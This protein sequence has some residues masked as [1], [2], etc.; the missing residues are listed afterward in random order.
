MSE[1]RQKAGETRVSPT[2]SSASS[3]AAASSRR[4]DSRPPGLV[5]YSG[6][7]RRSP[8]RSSSDAALSTSPDL[9]GTFH[10]LRIAQLSDIHY[11]NYSEPAFVRHAVQQINALA[12][13]LVLF[14]GDFV[15]RAP[16]MYPLTARH[17]HL[18]AEILKDVACSQ[19][20]ARPRQSRRRR[21]FSVH[22]HR[23]PGRKR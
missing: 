17:A 16:E 6:E 15:T 14:T 2:G 4:P 10:G 20:Y 21:R 22:D 7:I 19:R 9:P 5:L 23:S 11:D 12:P 18:C 1:S 3:A 13:D 8:T